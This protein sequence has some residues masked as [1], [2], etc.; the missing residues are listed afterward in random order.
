MDQQDRFSGMT[1]NERLY[2][3][4][5]LSA[6]DVARHNKDRAALIAL[7]CKVGVN[8]PERTIDALIQAEY[9]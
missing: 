2:E 1:L 9:R 3:A 8:S 6:F 7:C 5:L 4:G